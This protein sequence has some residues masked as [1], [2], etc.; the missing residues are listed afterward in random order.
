[1]LRRFVVFVS[2]FAALLGGLCGVLCVSPAVADETGSIHVHKYK[3]APDASLKHDGTE[4]SVSGRDPLE[5][6]DFD[7]YEVTGLDLKKNGDV[8]VASQIGQMKLTAAQVA[9]G[10]ITVGGTDYVCLLYTSPSPRD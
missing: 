7:V 4:Q 10:K 1:M 5:G 6:I 8:K 3:G 9:G 2:G